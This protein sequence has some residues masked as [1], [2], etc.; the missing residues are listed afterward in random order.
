MMKQHDETFIM[1]VS[2]HKTSKT[3][4]APISLS[5]NLKSNLDVYVRHVRPHFAKENED[6][7]FVTNAGIPFPPGTIGKR[8]TTWWRK[9]TGKANV[10]STRLRKMHASKLHSSTTVDKRSAHRLMCHTERTAERYYMIHDLSQVAAQGHSVLRDNINLEDTVPTNADRPEER[11]LPSSQSKGGF[12]EVELKEIHLLFHTVIY[13]NDP[14]TITR[15]KNQMSDSV[16]FIGLVQD[17]EI[18]SKIYK[19]VQYLQSK[20]RHSQADSSDA[21]SEQASDVTSQLSELSQGK[22]G[23]RFRWSEEDVKIITT[24]FQ[25]FKKCPL[26]ATIK[27]EVDTNPRL[28]AIVDRNGFLR[29][30]DKVRN[31]F[32]FRK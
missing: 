22:E 32:R 8:I 24:A 15:V 26:K 14:L 11:D 3:G 25:T 27:H 16:N 29:F 28:K 12:T 5:N 18:V 1:Y 19:H 17:E 20:H 4:P 7:L 6:A 23:G 9:A 10:T 30:Y 21:L 13:K 31:V 2:R